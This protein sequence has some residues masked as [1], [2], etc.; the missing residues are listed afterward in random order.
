[1][2][3]VC[4]LSPGGMMPL[5]D[6][7]LTSLII[8]Y[9]GSMILIDCGEGTQILLKKLK[10]GFKAIDVICLTHY[11][12]DHVA[13]LPG[14][15]STIGNSN[16]TEPITIIGPKGLSEIVSGLKVIVPHLPY[17]LN[18]IEVGEG[19]IKEYNYKDYIIRHM[20]VEHG[21]HCLAYSIEVKRAKKFNR[22]KAEALGVPIILWNKLQK[23][24]VVYYNNKVFTPDMV[25][26]E[27]RKGL[28]I[29]YCTDSRPISELIDF[30]KES[31]LFIG[32][33]MYGDD[34]YLEKAQMNG[35]MLFSEC[36]NLAKMAEVK[37]LW[38]THFSP[39]L[40]N[41][42]EFL[43]NA[44]KIFE[45]TKLGQELL[46]RELTFENL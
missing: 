38:L 40:Y 12:A 30:I 15:L 1:M 29:S 32:E 18:L 34:I 26:G 10:W 5:P 2:L 7:Y 23:E 36:A 46:E 35:H 17:E 42:Q 31:D 41:P 8:N 27:D 33:G 39:L 22:E 16:R 4:L 28:K 6:R 9:R 37:E 14:L 13:G 20:C 25:L 44:T 45:N 24:E 11:H 43:H 19:D 21:I 3:K